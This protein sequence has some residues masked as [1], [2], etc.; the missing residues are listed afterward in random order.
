[1]RRILDEVAKRRDMREQRR[2]VEVGKKEV[3]SPWSVV[4]VKR[5]VWLGLE[6]PFT[7]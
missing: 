1:M 6:K 3:V 2:K 4:K 7:P 5:R